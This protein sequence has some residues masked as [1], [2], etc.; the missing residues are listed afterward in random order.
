[1]LVCKIK[2]GGWV[3]LRFNG[4]DAWVQVAAVGQ[5]SARLA[6]EAPRA[7]D[8]RRDELLPDPEQYV[9]VRRD[10]RLASLAACLP[11]APEPR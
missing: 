9:A 5:E 10:S 2:T 11:P 3:R 1:M 7:V 8:I 4:A 6:F